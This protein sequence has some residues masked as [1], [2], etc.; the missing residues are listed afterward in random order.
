MYKKYAPVAQL[1][2]HRSYEPK[3]QGS[4]PCGSNFIFFL[5]IKYII[6]NTIVII[7]L[8]HLLIPLKKSKDI[9]N[10]SL[11]KQKFNLSNDI[12][13]IIKFFLLDNTFF[14]NLWQNRMLETLS[15]ID[16]GYKLVPVYKFQNYNIFN[17]DNREM[18]YYCLECYLESLLKKKTYIDNIFC[19]NCYDIITSYPNIEIKYKMLSYSE[20]KLRQEL[21]DISNLYGY[22]QIKIFINSSKYLTES[23]LL[24]NKSFYQTKLAH[25]A[26]LYEIKNGPLIFSTKPI[27]MFQLKQLQQNKLNN[28][29]KV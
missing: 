23:I 4:S 3:V 22:K 28:Y 21:K 2:E 17:R 14:K 15:I 16:K 18:D 8:M 26:L 20:F 29:F 5:N 24:G 19:I 9:D 27:F 11:L 7:Y 10:V 12:I 1:V 6:T 13:N 25:L